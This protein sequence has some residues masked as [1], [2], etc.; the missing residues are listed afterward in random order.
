MDGLNIVPSSPSM[1]SIAKGV[2]SEGV[3]WMHSHSALERMLLFPKD[4]V[5]VDEKYGFLFE[6]TKKDDFVFNG[7]R[8]IRVPIMAFV[9][10]GGRF[11]NFN[12]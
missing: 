2:S 10:R 8:Y 12:K 5:L 6:D 9:R 1:S 7:V 11:G 4:R 3:V